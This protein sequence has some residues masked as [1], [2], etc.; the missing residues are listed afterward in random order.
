MLLTRKVLGLFERGKPVR[1]LELDLLVTIRD[2]SFVNPIARK[3]AW[4]KQWISD[5]VVW[6]ICRR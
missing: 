1:R 6:N 2:K 3:L 4:K 5:I